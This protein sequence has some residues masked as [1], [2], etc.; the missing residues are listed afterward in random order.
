MSY[1]T[2]KRADVV[3]AV[4]EKPHRVVYIPAPLDGAY[5]ED[6]WPELADFMAQAVRWTLKGKLPVETDAEE[7][8]WLV[9]RRNEKKKSWFRR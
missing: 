3:L 2:E 9:L 6:G 1:P 7:N 5:W 4:R 8:I